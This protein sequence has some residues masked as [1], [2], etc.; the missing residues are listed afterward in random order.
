MR[1]R[2][3]AFG[4]SLSLLTVT[5]CASAPDAGEDTDETTTDATGTSGATSGDSSEEPALQCPPDPEDTQPLTATTPWPEVTGSVARLREYVQDVDPEYS[6]ALDSESSGVGYTLYNIQM[7]SLRWRPEGEITPGVWNHWMTI[8]VPEEITTSKAH[9][10][11]V[12]GSVSAELPVM[13]EVALLVQVARDTGSPVVVLGQIPAQPTTAPDR[14]EPMKEDDLVAYSWR[15]AM[16]TQDPTWAAYFPMTKASVRAMD[17]TQAFLK[18]TLGHA[19]DGFI[20]TGFS[21]RGAT[22]WL[23]AAADDR[24]EAVVPGVFPA[25]ELG[26]LAET[27]FTRYGEFAEATGSYVNEHILQEIRAPEGYFLRGVVDLINYRDALTMPHYVLQ[28][29]GDEFFLPDAARGFLDRIPGEATQ[30]II[31]NESHGLDK[32][33][34]ENLSGLIAWYQVILAGQPRPTLTE[35]LRDGVV[36]IK[37]DQEPASVVLWSAHN[38]ELPDFRF[39]TIGGAWE[40]TP[41]EAAAPRTYELALE[42]SGE[43]YDAYVVELRFPGVEGSS[44]EQLYTSHVYLAPDEPPFTLDQPAGAPVGLPQRRC[45]AVDGAAALTETLAGA[46]P[47]VVRGQHITDAAALLE[48]LGRG[49]TIDAQAV[50]QCAAARLNVELANLGWYTRTPDDAFVWEHLATAEHEDAER[51]ALRCQALNN[52]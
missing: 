38:P 20:V 35:S 7:D 15:K 22:A 48:L 13:A 44:H 16:D 31:P 19:P 6:Y 25:L 34:D 39:D 26:Q 12:G 42:S 40:P 1:H 4:V 50:A 46:L 14:P 28:A 36:T 45:D 3:A 49:D 21:K 37:A 41:L 9:L 33:L 30:R 24:V 43:G 32:N 8:I 52:L 51:A 47:I 5:A 17:T 10:V 27:M 29:S 23:T 11:I 18:E 2:A